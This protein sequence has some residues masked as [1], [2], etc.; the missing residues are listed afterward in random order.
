MS[1]CAYP[2][3]DQWETFDSP[4]ACCYFHSKVLVGRIDHWTPDAAGRPAEGT[5]RQ[6]KGQARHHGRRS[7]A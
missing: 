5:F 3:C 1:R 2:G 6:H 7:A 4:N